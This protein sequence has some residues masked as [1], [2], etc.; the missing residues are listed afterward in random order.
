MY[1]QNG[2]NHPFQ[3]IQTAQLYEQRQAKQQGNTLHTHTRGC[4]TR[5]GETAQWSRILAACLSRY[6]GLIPSTCT[7]AHTISNSSPRGSDVLM[8]TPGMQEGNRHMQAKHSYIYFKK[9]V[10]LIIGG[11]TKAIE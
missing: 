4:Q 8:Q 7:V 5:A 9:V 2:E 1:T 6:L 3:G 10:E 11:C